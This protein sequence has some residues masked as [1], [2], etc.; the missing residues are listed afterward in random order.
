[1]FPSAYGISNCAA[2]APVPFCSAG[3]ECRFTIN[4]WP[5]RLLPPPNACAKPS[6]L[7]TTPSRIDRLSDPLPSSGYS[8]SRTLLRG[9]WSLFLFPLVDFSAGRELTFEDA[10]PHCI[11]PGLCRVLRVSGIARLETSICQGERSPSPLRHRGQGASDHIPARLPGILVRVE[12]S[13]A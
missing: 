1:M 8:G 6:G 4:R 9:F 12:G 3:A 7:A 13:V 11:S 2:S 5:K 10:E